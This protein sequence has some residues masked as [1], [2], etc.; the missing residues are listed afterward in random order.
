MTESSGVDEIDSAEHL[1]EV[2]P[3]F[4]PVKVVLSWSVNIVEQLTPRDKFQN[5]VR[6][7]SLIVRFLKHLNT[8]FVVMNHLNCVSVP[9]QFLVNLNFLIESIK[10]SRFIK[11]NFD[12]KVSL[13]IVFSK[14]R[15]GLSSILLSQS[16]DATVSI[17]KTVSI[18]QLIFCVLLISRFFYYRPLRQW[19]DHRI[20]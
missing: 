10:T 5:Y 20:F 16:F 13:L 12:C 9:A 6:A 8:V 11:E 1:L 2:K 17:I 3:N 18:Y 19:F 14:P 7:I 4:F 15:S